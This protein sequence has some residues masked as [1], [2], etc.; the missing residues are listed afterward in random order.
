MK[1]ATNNFKLGLFTLAGLVILIVGVLAFGAR[2]YLKPTTSFETYVAGDVTGLAV[3]SP[4]ELRGVEVGKVTRIAFSWIEYQLT[5]PSYIVVEFEI[6]DD[7][8]PAPP[9]KSHWNQ[10]KIEIESGLRARLKSQGITGTTILSLEY[11]DPIRNPPVQVPWTPRNIYIPAAPG[12]FVEILAS[13]QKS[14]R[15]V[16]QIDFRDINRLVHDD[17]ISAGRVLDKAG[18]VDF[19]SLSTNANA[20][21]TEL[22]DSNTKLQ[23]IIQVTD[24]TVKKIKL[25]KLSQDLDGLVGQLRDTVARI[26]P[27]LANIDFDEVNRTMANARQTLHDLD[28]VLAELKNYPSGFFLGAP[29]LPVKEVQPPAK[30]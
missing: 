26:Q 11:L 29:P 19:Q 23:S 22:R 12:Q 16:E 7:V 14:L 17:L 25:E 15:N 8:S 3:G 10:L 5:Q 21:L 18:Q 24:D 2:G 30:P 13:I 4:V 6:Q 1:R 9:G 28:D 27:G 20:L